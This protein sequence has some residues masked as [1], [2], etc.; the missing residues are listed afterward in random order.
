[1]SKIKDIIEKMQA[2]G[3]EYNDLHLLIAKRV[4]LI[5]ASLYY[6]SYLFT[7]GGYYF[8]PITLDHL[9]MITFHLFSVL[10]IATTWFFYTVCEYGIIVYIPRRKWLLILPTVI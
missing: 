7:V 4:W 9:S 1:M 10:I 3:N 2:T 6:L 8:G 5:V